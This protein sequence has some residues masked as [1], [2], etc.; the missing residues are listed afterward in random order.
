MTKLDDLK[1]Y[2]E[3]F[4]IIDIIFTRSSD[5]LPTLSVTA[6][7]F[8][9]LIQIAEAAFEMPFPIFTE[10]MGM[11]YER[12][13]CS[14]CFSDRWEWAEIDGDSKHKKVNLI[15]KENCLY[16]RMQELKEE[17]END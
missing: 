3:R 7:D 15:H 14:L 2:V 13:S 16:R 8:K 4:D 5:M 11:G 1:D 10:K 6:K 17:L 9:T 12:H